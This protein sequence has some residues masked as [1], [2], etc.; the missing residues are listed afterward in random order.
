MNLLPNEST[1]MEWRRGD[2]VMTTDRARLDMDRVHRFLAEES[3]WAKGMARE[4]IL[5]SIRGS[6]PIGIYHGGEQVAFARLI[7]D[8]TRMAYLI[9]V[10]VDTRH[11]GKGLGTWIGASVREHPDLAGVGRWL[12][13]TSD[14]HDVYERAGWRRSLHPDWIMEADRPVPKAAEAEG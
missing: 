14:A 12:L 13:T 5:R 6:M 11:R 1:V 7:T 10:F 2:Y 9:D 4:R 8:F 3:Y